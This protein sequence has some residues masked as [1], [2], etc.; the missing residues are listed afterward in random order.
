MSVET[1]S[2]PVIDKKIDFQKAYA[3]LANSLIIEKLDVYERDAL[4]YMITKA[5]T[6]E[7]AALKP[8]ENPF[9]LASLFMA[10]KDPRYYLCGIHA[11][12]THLIAINGHMIIMVEHACEPGVYDALGVRIPDSS[13]WKLPDVSRYFKL[14][15]SP[16]DY[17]SGE[18]SIVGH[19]PARLL[20]GTKFDINYLKLLK[21]INTK[22]TGLSTDT[23]NNFRVL[24][25]V[26][27]NFKG[28]L[29]PLNNDK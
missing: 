1:I 10:K 14:Q 17:L 29:M 5:T 12:G 6:K 27:D 22:E 2:G 7:K 19:T 25:F 13:E 21:R 24:Q 23:I 9:K 3:A 4:R 20:G 18:E 15:F 26:G 16:V 28:I 11:T 8:N